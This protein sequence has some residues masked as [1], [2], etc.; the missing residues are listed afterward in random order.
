MYS[1]QKE[2]LSDNFKKTNKT[3][4][5]RQISKNVKIIVC[6]GLPVDEVLEDFVLP[7]PSAIQAAPSVLRSALLTEVLKY[8]K[9]KD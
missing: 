3:R 7:E 8:H 9:I 5:E 2:K 1:E 4:Q 6:F